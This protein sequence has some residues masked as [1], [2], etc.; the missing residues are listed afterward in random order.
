MEE[1]KKMEDYV[2]SHKQSWNEGSFKKF[3]ETLAEVLKV[4]NTDT[5]T[6]INICIVCIG[7]IARVLETIEDT[8]TDTEVLIPPTNRAYP[9]SMI[10]ATD[11]G[12][13]GGPEAVK[14][15]INVLNKLNNSTIKDSFLLKISIE[16]TIMLYG[17]VGIYSTDMEDNGIYRDAAD[18]IVRVISDHNESESDENLR[19]FKW[20]A[21]YV[22]NTIANFVKKNQIEKKSYVNAIRKIIIYY[23][24]S[25]KWENIEV[26]VHILGYINK[27]NRAAPKFKETIQQMQ[28]STNA[29]KDKFGTWDGNKWINYISN[30]LKK[31][32]YLRDDDGSKNE[33][34]S[35]GTASEFD[36]GASDSSDE[37]GAVHGSSEAS[38]DWSDWDFEDAESESAASATENENL[39]ER[40]DLAAL[41]LATAAGA[42]IMHKNENK[43]FLF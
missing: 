40:K 38:G 31:L 42:Y 7:I 13:T 5:D 4:N 23:L 12:R 9:V 3:I 41:G 20:C 29:V 6:D 33:S 14:A 27:F 21:P 34:E 37:R 17:I 30:D 15:I 25:G 24:E 43:I 8:D 11:T 2:W 39:G 36:D 16:C 28:K 1:M 18:A 32:A 35:G 10:Y 22:F 26:C 19:R